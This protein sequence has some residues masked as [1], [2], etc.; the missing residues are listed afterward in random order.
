MPSRGNRRHWGGQRDTNT[1]GTRGHQRTIQQTNHCTSLS[2]ALGRRLRTLRAVAVQ[3]GVELLVSNSRNDEPGRTR[4]GGEKKPHLG[5]CLDKRG[6]T[7][8]GFRGV[9]THRMPGKRISTGGALAAWLA[10][11]EVP[12]WQGRGLGKK[13]S[14]TAW[15][16]DTHR[17]WQQPPIKAQVYRRRGLVSWVGGLGV[18]SGS[19]ILL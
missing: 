18:V 15:P 7:T 13:F 3:C 19:W 16:S 10:A 5:S 12:G 1:Q 17:L 2:S 4:R 11:P 8:G 6:R 9:C 14:R